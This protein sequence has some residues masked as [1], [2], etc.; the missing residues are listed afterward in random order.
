MHSRAAVDHWQLRQLTCMD[1]FQL[2][3]RTVANSPFFPPCSASIIQLLVS[4]LNMLIFS[5]EPMAVGYAQH[6]KMP[7][8]LIFTATNIL[9]SIRL[10]ELL[11]A[12]LDERVL[13]YATLAS[14]CSCRGSGT[15]SSFQKSCLIFLLLTAEKA[16]AQALSASFSIPLSSSS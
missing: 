15:S 4:Y 11:C 9:R 6:P 12:P 3:L 5:Y 10:G 7:H 14:I 16:Q 1:Y 8:G 13:V 2:H